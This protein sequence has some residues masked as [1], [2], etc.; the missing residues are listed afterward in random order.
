MPDTSPHERIERSWTDNAEAWTQVVRDGLIP[1]RQAGTDA[2]IVAACL[3]HGTG[4][5]LDVGCGEGWLV[6]ELSV[7]GVTAT[8]IDV[9]AALITRAREL[10]G[11]DFSVATYAQ[12]ET[13]PLIA[14]GPWQVIACNFA[15]LGDP[16]HALLA[17][18][19][20]RLAPGGRVLVQTVHSWTARG[21]APYRSE[22]RT[23]AFDAFAVAFPT[24]MPWYYRTLASW[25]EQFAMA[26]LRVVSLDE[27]LHP[28]TGQP[29]SLLFHCE[30]A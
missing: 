11:G 8:G 12:L 3:S 22:W 28:A 29:L 27:P 25:H 1:S 23:E 17:A 5:V 21:D 16:L 4:P 13:D 26:G 24:P 30:A 6:R 18:L 7:R 2:A 20:A 10:G 15:L 19:R 9:S 14:V